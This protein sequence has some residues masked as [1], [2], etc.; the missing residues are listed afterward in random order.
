[1]VKTR[2]SVVLSRKNGN[3]RLCTV[4]PLSGS[5]PE[6]LQPWHHKMDRSKLPERMQKNDWWAKCDCIATVCFDRLDRI[7]M[8]K[9][10]TTGKRLYAAPKVYGE[11][12][13]A[14]KLA[15]IRHL[16]FSDLIPIGT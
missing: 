12:L 10:P 9:C 1:M 15:I 13:L 11:D 5:E 7:W 4:V 16:G 3:V 2:P 6:V 8:G 14:I